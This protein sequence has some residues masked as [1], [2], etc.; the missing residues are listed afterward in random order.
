MVKKTK[1]AA[2]ASANIWDAVGGLDTAKDR[3]I[4]AL[5][6]PMLCPKALQR[7]GIGAARG[8]LL[9]GPPGVGK[10]LLARTAAAVANARFVEVS[11]P[12]ILAQHPDAA[13]QALQAAFASV[14]SDGPAIMFINELELLAPLRAANIVEPQRNDRIVN[15]LIAEIDRLTASATAVLIGSS[16][17]PNL[18]DPA[19]L[20]PGRLDELVYAA[21][22][23]AAGRLAILRLMTADVAVAKNVDLGDL[24]ERTE[25]F[26]AA[27]FVD[28][29]RRAG[30]NALKASTAAKHIAKADFDASLAETRASV[31]DAMEKEYEKVHGEIRANALKLEPMGFLGAGQLKPVRDSKHGIAER[32]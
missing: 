4:D 3:L 18:I 24:A 26:T 16:C 23:D 6:A 19:L 31:T 22:P 15:L 29:I 5:V 14:A 27:D 11:G 17:R 9:Y 2:P 13:A 25:R 20:R 12:D 21:V 7:L 30:L 8:F 1:A 28:L 32:A 10:A